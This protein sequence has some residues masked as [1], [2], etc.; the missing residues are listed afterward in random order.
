MGNVETNVRVLPCAYAALQTIVA[1]RGLSRD[2]TVRRLL[3]EYVERQEHLDP[4]ERLTHVSTVLR[5]PLPA[6]WPKAPRPDRPLRLRLPSDLGPRARAVSLRLAGQSPRAHRDYQS[7][8]L[9][10]A[11]MTAIAVE[12][13]FVDEVLDGLL[14]LLRHGSARGLWYLAVAATSTAPELAVLTKAEI[15]RATGPGSPPRTSQEER[16]LLVAEALEQEV[17]WHGSVRFQVAANI[18]RDLLTGPNA[19]QNEK[20]LHQQGQQWE[21]LLVDL[22]DGGTARARYRA[23]V[24]E[25]SGVGRGATAVWRAERL[26]ES[27]NFADWLINASV[28]HPV[29]RKIRPP[30]WITRLPAHWHG[31]RV[32]AAAPAPEPYAGWLANGRVLAFRHQERHVV[33]PLIP[34]PGRPGLAPVPGIEPVLRAASKV[35]ADQLVAFIEAILIDWSGED[36]PFGIGDEHPE[37]DMRLR[38][39]VDKAHE[40]GFLDALEKRRAMTDARAATLRSMTDIIKSIPSSEPGLRR[41]LE[42]AYG[43]TRQFGRIARDARKIWG[44]RF[45]FT[46]TQAWW[47]WPGGSVADA[48]TAGNRPDLVECLAGWAFRQSS[49]ILELVMRRAW[50]DAFNDYRDV[51]V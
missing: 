44:V 28:D 11:V 10:D 49:L 1:R 31:R 45:N 43:N 12:E 36:D 15:L 38:L 40:F 35:R 6:F 30:G 42:E 13:P 47:Y 9:T 26:V 27:Q 16:L 51:S 4:E 41:R 14:P 24:I 33:W 20:M 46:V 37:F 22:R 29:K 39:P 17:A 19:A 21:R 7:R 2:E 25:A 34:T 32:A 3:S 50:D 18:A 5:Y 23:G 48:L 8:S